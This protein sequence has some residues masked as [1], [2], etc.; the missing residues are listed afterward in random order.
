VNNPI[1]APEPEPDS[2]NCDATY[3]PFALYDEVGGQ[4]LLWYNGR[5]GDLER[6]GV[7]SLK[8]SFGRFVERAPP[9]EQLWY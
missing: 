7:S 5:C 6:I 2:W 4:W 8:G 9:A 1:V 3:K